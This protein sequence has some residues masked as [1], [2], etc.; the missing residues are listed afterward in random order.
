[1][2]VHKL[3]LLLFF[4]A[5]SH[6]PLHALSAAEPHL[7][8]QPTTKKEA[9][10]KSKQPAPEAEK[11]DEGIF[12]GFTSALGGKTAALPGKTPEEKLSMLN[13]LLK[14]GKNLR[15]DVAAVQEAIEKNPESADN[16]EFV[17]RLNALNQQ[18][19]ESS[20]DFERIATGVELSTFDPVSQQKQFNWKE[21]VSA[22]LDPMIKEMR[23]LT[24]TTKQKADLREQIDTLAKQVQTAGQAMDNLNTLSKASQDDTMTRQLEDLLGTWKNEQARLNGKLELA[25]MELHTLS[26]QSGSLLEKI[27][28]GLS[29]FFKTRGLYLF[30]GLLAFAFTFFLL[31]YLISLLLRHLPKDKHGRPRMYARLITIFAHF[32]SVFLAMIALLAVFYI[33]ADWFMISLV[34]LLFIG[35]LW[36]VRQTLPGQWQ[37]SLLMLNMG[38]VR[39]GERL[40]LDSVPWRVD[41]LGVFCRISNPAL[42]QVRRIP[43]EHMLKLVSRSYDLEEPWFPC[44]KGDYIKLDE[45]TVVQVSSLSHEQVEVVRAGMATIYPTADFLGMAAANMSQKFTVSTTLG[46]SYDLQADV[47]GHIPTIL[48]SYLHKRLDE[49][50]YSSKC[51]SRTCEF[52]LANNS[53]LDIS[54]ILEF[55]GDMASLFYRL[56]R[57]LQRWCV[58]CCT[59]NQWEI[60]YNQIVV[61]T[62]AQA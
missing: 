24:A 49:E 53:T 45:N 41:S 37:Q 28:D 31:R 12:P 30:L 56:R 19:N 11:E 3:L 38:P 61:H 17:A 62:A 46:L 60:P 8:A 36:A 20:R 32:A 33:V 42:D 55:E 15:Q 40:V 43:I 54:V 14:Q 1:M 22:L 18:L 26:T 27:M 2:T 57:A 10:S 47:T 5:L 16:S 58:D 44:K 6:L 51:L 52:G 48:R 39:E 59:E 7:Q 29:R 35:M 50:G 21:E 34:L 9:Q 4:F 23:D 13:A 25:Q